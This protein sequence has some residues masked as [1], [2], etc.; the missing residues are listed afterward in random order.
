MPQPG[1]GQVH[2]GRPAGSPRSWRGTVPEVCRQ[3]LWLC[4]ACRPRRDFTCSLEVEKLLRKNQRC[5]G[6][7]SHGLPLCLCTPLRP[8]LL[9]QPRGSA[10]PVLRGHCVLRTSPI[11]SGA[12]PVYSP[13]PHTGNWA[14]YACTCHRTDPHPRPH[15]Q[16]SPDPQYPLCHFTKCHWKQLKLKIQGLQQESC[17]VSVKPRP[18]PPSKHRR[19]WW[20]VSTS[21]SR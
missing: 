12:S 7:P 2:G 18:G 13:E 9:S 14:Q 3:K 19:V 15:F 8:P 20:P 10:A 5:R 6:Q 4:P 1:S 17:G 16:H 21:P 11:N